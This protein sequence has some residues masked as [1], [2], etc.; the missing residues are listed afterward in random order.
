MFFKQPCLLCLRNLIFGIWDPQREIEDMVSVS[1]TL[2]SFP[3]A[4]NKTGFSALVTLIEMGWPLTLPLLDPISFSLSKHCVEELTSPGAHKSI[5]NGWCDLIWIALMA[6]T[7]PL[8]LDSPAVVHKLNMS[9]SAHR[10]RFC[11]HCK[12][13]CQELRIFCTLLAIFVYL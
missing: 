12:L 6:R 4:P 13:N 7:N 3:C 11:S 10:G 1:G 8:H 5:C 9:I 2:R